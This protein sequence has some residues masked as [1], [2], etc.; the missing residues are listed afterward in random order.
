VIRI[1]SQRFD[2][3]VILPGIQPLAE[4][5]EKAFLLEADFVAP[6]LAHILGFAALRI[7]AAPRIHLHFCMRQ[8]EGNPCSDGLRL[9]LCAFLL[10]EIEHLV[11]P[12]AFRGLSPEFSDYFHDRS[13]ACA[14]DGDAVNAPAAALQNLLKF[15]PT[16]IS[17][18]RK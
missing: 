7:H 11:V 2:D 8:K 4:R 1:S 3:V 9:N 16:H 6:A 10:Q 12:A 18:S 5:K 15:L 14:V 13:Q 17:S